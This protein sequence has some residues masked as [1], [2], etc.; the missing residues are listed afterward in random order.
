MLARTLAHRFGVEV[1]SIQ[2]GFPDCEARRQVRPGRWQRVRIEIEFESRSFAAHGHDAKACDVIVCW[3]H[4]WKRCPKELEVIEIGEDRDGR[5]HDRFLSVI[6]MLRQQPQECPVPAKQMLHGC[7]ARSG[8]ALS[9][10]GG[11]RTV[12]QCNQRGMQRTYSAGEAHREGEYPCPKV[13]STNSF[14]Q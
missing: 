13:G 3:R 11:R 2:A 14:D 6:A 5:T 4:N 12:M 7:V 8:V 9:C 1:E 10:L